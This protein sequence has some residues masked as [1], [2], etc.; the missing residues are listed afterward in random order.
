[1]LPDHPVV[2]PHA[3]WL[4]DPDTIS[5][6]IL[7]IKPSMEEFKRVIK[8]MFSHS[9]TD[10]FYDMEVINDLY[11]GSAMILPNEHW[12]VSG[13]F[14]LKSHHKYLDE[15]ETWDP[16][17]VLNQ[18]KLVHFSDWPRPKP[19]F[20]VTRETLYKT[21]PTC[22][23]MPGSAHKDCRNRDAWNWLYADFEERRGV[24]ATCEAL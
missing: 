21:Q 14:R 19:W 11:A 7:L 4:P 9:S 2:A 24:R 18:T 1:L 16:D 10:E 8:S 22:D 20:P 13:E 15:G 12:V 17:R 6:A 23:T 5:S 3:Y